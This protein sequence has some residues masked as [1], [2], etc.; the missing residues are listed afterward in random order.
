M[1]ELN[2]HRIAYR[3]SYW[4]ASHSSQVACRI[5]IPQHRFRPTSR[6]SRVMGWS[7][8]LGRPAWAQRAIT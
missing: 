7:R 3:G 8:F 2:P 4:G 6:Q 1:F 5:T